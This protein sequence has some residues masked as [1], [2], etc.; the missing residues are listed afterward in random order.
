MDLTGSPTVRA[1]LEN[2]VLLG[3]LGSFLKAL[4]PGI[5]IYKDQVAVDLGSFIEDT[6]QKKLLALI[7]SVHIKT[8]V[9]RIILDVRAEK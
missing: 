2:K 1:F 8:D 6:E 5:T 9:G 3:R 7:K 4:P